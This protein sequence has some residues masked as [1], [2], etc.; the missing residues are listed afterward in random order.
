MHVAF[1]LYVKHRI[2]FCFF[3]IKLL[4]LIIFKV[5]FPVVNNFLLSFFRI[6]EGVADTSLR[7]ETS[8]D[9]SLCLFKRNYTHNDKSN[10]GTS[11]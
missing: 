5:K 3:T 7:H 11:Y 1:S 2:E 6:V 8:F 10:Q 9:T 4:F